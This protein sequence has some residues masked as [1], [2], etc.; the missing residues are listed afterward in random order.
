M[1][2][3]DTCS[4]WVFNLY[5]FLVTSTNFFC[6]NRWHHYQKNPIWLANNQV[7]KLRVL[8]YW[9]F[10][11]R[12]GEMVKCHIVFFDHQ[13]SMSQ[14]WCC[15]GSCCY[16]KN[17]KGLKTHWQWLTLGSGL[18]DGSLYWACPI[19]RPDFLFYVSRTCQ[20]S[21]LEKMQISR[22]LE[23]YGKISTKNSNI[24]NIPYK[25]KVLI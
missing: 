20:S 8:T 3:W 25:H 5:F 10:V 15:L 14:W 11:V 7:K 16:M 1:K 23:I 2:F 22:Q 12:V 4:F 9:K 19:W 18:Y 13:L 6:C 24:S 21:G 17:E